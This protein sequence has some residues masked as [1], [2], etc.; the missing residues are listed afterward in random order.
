VEPRWIYTYDYAPDQSWTIYNNDLSGDTYRQEDYIFEKQLYFRICIRKTN[1]EVFN[2]TGTAPKDINDIIHF[3]TKAQT[4]R[5]AKQK[6]NK[7]WIT[8]EAKRVVKRIN[9]KKELGDMAF[10]L[11]TDTHYNV[12]GTWEDTFDAVEQLCEEI[13]LTGIIHLGDLSDGMVTGEA[14]R[15][16]AK[17]VLNDLKSFGVPVWLTL[18]NHDT[19]YFRRNPEPFSIKQQKELY[20]SGGDVHYC[21]DLHKVHNN[22][23]LIFLD[24]YDPG[25]ELR[26]GYSCECI[27]W[28]ENTLANTPDNI[29][30]IIF[31]HLPPV[32][33]L[34]FWT[35][36]IRG[37][38]EILEVIK[39]HQ[40]KMLAWINGHNHADRLDDN[41][42]FPIVSVANAKCE[43]F[44][45][46]KTEGFVTP[47]R[48]L[49]DR[50]QEAFD[51][52]LVNAEK[53]TIRFIRYGSGKDR[54]IQKGK[55]QWE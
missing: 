30:T 10:V 19:N 26:Y 48:K 18:G 5:E 35:K 11:M 49:N 37:E 21:V 2:E 43:A 44:T 40:S 15:Y 55:T 29:K 47:E 3:E 31:S 9:S 7:K 25:E 38:A 23:R 1:G 20:F 53:E 39:T 4:N 50:T 22:L 34:Q 14:T 17:T 51:I 13:D 28:L 32:A 36:Q 54:I 45:E 46:R 6:E 27:K 42:G 16:Y 33:R 8:D 52:I 41:E 24:S 12:N